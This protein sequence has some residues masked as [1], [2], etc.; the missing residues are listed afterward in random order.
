MRDQGVRPEPLVR[1]RAADLLVIGLREEEA[2]AV[3]EIGVVNVELVAVI[4]QRQRM[5][6]ILGQAEG[7]VRNGSRSRLVEFPKPD[8]LRPAPIAVAQDML[9]KSAGSTGS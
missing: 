4:A 8:P 9:G 3:A 7:S 1:D 5:R 6:V 2:A